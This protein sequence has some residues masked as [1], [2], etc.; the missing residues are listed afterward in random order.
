MTLFELG[1]RTDNL[2]QTII[3]YMVFTIIG[4]IFLLAVSKF[5]KRKKLKNRK[6]EK[7]KKLEPRIRVINN[8]KNSGCYVSLNKGIKR[9]K[10]VF[11][12]RLDSD[13]TIHPD[14]LKIQVN[15]LN[16]HSNKI[17]VYCRRNE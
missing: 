5:L 12:S 13:D 4:I 3:P 6:I 17:M 10:G 8:K 2:K 11:I 7:Y 14:K 16:K 9:S 15:Y 1:I